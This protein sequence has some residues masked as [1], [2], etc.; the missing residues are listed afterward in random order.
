M[1]GI[2]GILDFHRPA[3]AALVDSMVDALVHRGPDD[4]GTFVEGELGFGMRRLSIIDLSSGHQPIFSE[5]ERQ[6]IVFN[7]EI[8]NFQELKTELIE[9]GH[10]FRTNSDTEVILHLYEEYGTECPCKLQGMFAFAI[11]HR[12]KKELFIA[13]DRFGI[14]PLFYYSTNA[15]FAFSSELKGLF[16]S[17]ELQRE[18]DEGAVDEF[19]TFLYVP[20]EKTLFR[21][22]KKL[23]PGHYMKVRRGAVETK[24]Y[25]RLIP[26]SSSR[27][28]SEE[29]WIERLSEKLRKIVKMHLVSDVPLGAFLSGG[30]DSSLIVGVMST[31]LNRPVETFSIGY[32]VSG[33]EF[34]ERYYARLVSERFTTNHRELIV[35]PDMVVSCLPVLLSRLDEPFGDASVIPNYFLSE[36]ARQHV[37]VAMSG[38]GGDEMC[39]GYE[40]YLGAML[41]EKFRLPLSLVFNPLVTEWISHLPDSQSGKHLPERLKRFSKY[42]KLPFGERYLSFITK[43]TEEEKRELYSKDFLATRS[44]EPGARAFQEIWA[45]AGDDNGLHRLLRT[46]LASYLVDDLL[47]LSDRTSMAHSLEMRVPF[48]DHEMV[49]FFWTVPESM[50]LHGLSKKYLLKR[51]AERVLPREVI[52]RRKKGFS[53]PLTVWFRGV[54]KPYI[55]EMLSEESVRQS[56]LFN[57]AYIRRLI[58][59]HT[60][61]RRNHDERIFSLLSF[62]AWQRTYSN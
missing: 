38:L 24:R 61:G 26:A 16:C 23:L 2:A 27:F 46:D 31:L 57:I 32:D 12:D 30:I 35:T 20:R 50:K 58:D 29:E 34:D 14:K 33:A 54:L 3:E 11:W 42:A 10:V 37:T 22:V 25:Y 52:Y 36:F 40:R 43:F 15:A 18:L 39:G 5:D 56:G 28:I 19:F 21:G 8:Y 49:E 7:G 13:R 44:G 17:A 59:E 51:A 53:V 6:V 4:R 47:A 62:V 48:V 41:A 60:T 45:E 9:K 55:E 1:C